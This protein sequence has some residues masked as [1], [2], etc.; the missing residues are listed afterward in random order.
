MRMTDARDPPLCVPVLFATLCA[1]YRAM[2]GCQSPAWSRRA[3]RGKE[4]KNGPVRC[5]SACHRSN[6][7]PSSP[8]WSCA[9]RCA[10]CQSEL[11][12]F[13]PGRAASG[14]V[15][16]K[17]RAWGR[18]T[19]EGELGASGPGG[20][21]KS[22]WSSAGREDDMRSECILRRGD[23]SAVLRSGRCWRG[24]M[25]EGIVDDRVACVRT[26]PRPAHLFAPS[27]RQRG[28]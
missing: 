7:P 10:L 5:T 8:S 6:T 2:T 26:I 22:D 20:R 21:A 23:R 12:R 4:V 19:S 15:E 18:W 17:V 3:A 14:T 13:R 16:G 27:T 24:E 25:E 1:Y 11:S 9:T 28:K